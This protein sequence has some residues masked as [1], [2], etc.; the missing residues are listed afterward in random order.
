[1]RRGAVWVYT[2]GSQTQATGVVAAE[3]TAYRG[4]QG[5]QGYQGYHNIK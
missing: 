2:R 4:Y 5:Y 1:M 3:V